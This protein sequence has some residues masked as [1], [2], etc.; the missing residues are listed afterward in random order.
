M[1]RSMLFLHWKQIR[2]GLVLMAM[3]SFALPLMA[4]NGLGAPANLGGSGFQAY[5]L[6]SQIESF[7]PFFPVLAGLVG[8]TLGLSAWNWDHQLKHV[9]P[10][11]LPL[12]R[13]E[14]TLGK[15]LAGVTLSLV[16]VLGMWLGAHLAVASIALPPGLNAYPNALAVRFFFAVL[17]SYSLAFAIAAGT[18]RTAVTLGAVVFGFI[19]FGSI[20]NDLLEPRFDL[21]TRV[22]I[23]ETVL[24]WAL[25][26]P[27]PF[28]VFAGNWSLIDV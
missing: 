16:P 14:Y 3:A 5:G 26:A 1:Y 19:V 22:H 27:G 15:M 6:V 13:W 2:H 12:T 20:A 28:E 10:L 11:S 9:Y 21:F 17:L 18:V 24:I 7:L 25:E 23:V 8:I 4:V